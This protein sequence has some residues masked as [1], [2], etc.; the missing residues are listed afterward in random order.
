MGGNSNRAYGIGNRITI[1]GNGNINGPNYGNNQSPLAS[2]WN[3]G[4]SYG[5][6]NYYNNN[7]SPYY[8]PSPTWSPPYRRNNYPPSYSYYPYYDPPAT[9][10]YNPPP[11]YYSPPTPIYISSPRRVQTIPVPQYIPIPYPVQDNYMYDDDYDSGHCC[12]SMMTHHC[13]HGS[14]SRRMRGGMGYPMGYGGGGG[15]GG[16]PMIAWSD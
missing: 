5:A 1:G 13:D 14:R 6:P 11:T 8:S 12:T 3:P 15:F 4:A 16:L 2:N 7:S 9:Y 10:T